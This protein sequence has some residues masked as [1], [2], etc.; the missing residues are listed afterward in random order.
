[1]AIDLTI[2]PLVVP[3]WGLWEAVREILQGAIDAGV[4]YVFEYDKEKSLLLISNKGKLGKQ[5]LLIGNSTKREDKSK[6]G[7][8]G[9]GYKLA[10]A[11][12][13]RLDKKFRIYNNNE[14]WTFKYH[15]SSKFNSTLIRL[16][17]RSLF[18][19]TLGSII[20]EIGQVTPDEFESLSKKIQLKGDIKV[21]SG[22]I[23]LDK[24]GQIFSGNLFVCHKK[25][26][27]FGYNFNPGILELQRDRNLVSDFDI[28]W[29]TSVCWEHLPDAATHLRDDI[30]D[31]KYITYSTSDNSVKN[32]AFWLFT[33]TYGVDAVPCAKEAHKTAGRKN[34]I[35]SE[36]YRRA[37]T[38]SDFYSMPEPSQK[39]TPYEILSS[40]Y[41]WAKK[42]YLFTDENFQ[43]IL[44]KAEN[45]R[46]DD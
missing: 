3:D 5:S 16:D 38:G 33:K 15:Y 2:D 9:E 41:E 46:L 11:V 8:H 22:Y 40:W 27:A 31:V 25:D 4:P 23:L 17:I 30:P 37:I 14:I 44:E 20:W 12:L 21:P 39:Q 43:D 45:W 1:M 13:L 28:Y 35:V 42:E 32:A 7:Q 18:I 24:P 26:L 34:I 36:E 19:Q 6:I 29:Q 10:A